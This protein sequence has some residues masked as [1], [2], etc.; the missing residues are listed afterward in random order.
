MNTKAS[1]A[2]GWGILVLAGRGAYYFAKR[3]IK[4][5]RAERIEAIDRRHAAQHDTKTTEHG[6]SPNPRK[7][8]HVTEMSRRDEKSPTTAQ[9]ASI[10]FHKLE[11]GNLVAG[12]SMAL[13]SRNALN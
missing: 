9:L 13:D 11:G 7:K 6:A 1:V 3:T 2:Y 10:A 5:E 12:P 4:A 8:Q